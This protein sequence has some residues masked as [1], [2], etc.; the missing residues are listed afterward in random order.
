V[1]ADAG[2]RVAALRAA[3]GREIW[4]F[5]GGSLFRSLLA[6]KQVDIVEVAV[7]PV[8][9]GGG[10]PLLAAGAPLTRLVLE[11]VQRYPTGLLGVRY[12]VPEAAAAV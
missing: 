10:I 1:S 8:L 11:D 7:I 6:A 5:G 12:G 3:P 9:L 4:L 2:Q